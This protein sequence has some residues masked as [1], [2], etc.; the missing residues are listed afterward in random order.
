MEQQKYT[1]FNKIF[2]SG[3][4]QL[5]KNKI[6]DGTFSEFFGDWK[7]IFSFSKRYKWIIV[8][9]TFIGIFSSSFALIASY[10]GKNL[11]NIIVEKQRQHLW[12][13]VVTM[14]ASTVFSLVFSSVM[15]RLS[16][17]ISIYVNNDIQS[18]IFDK[19]IDARWSELNKYQSGD[20]LNRFNA[21]VNTISS[22]AIHW[23]PN[24]IINIYTFAVTFVV[25]FRMDIIMAVIAVTAA[26]FLLLMSRFIMRKMKEYKKRV[27]ELNSD[28]MSFEVETFFNFDMIKSFGIVGYYSR[29][30]K[31]WQKK[32][33][34]YNLDYNKFEIK[35][36]IL[37]TVL[38]TIVSL[39]AFGYCLFRLWT[40]Q[41]LYGDMTFF[42]EQRSSL[43]G[44]FNSLVG[45]F[46]AMMNSA[47]SAH[48]VRELVELQKEEHDP[49]SLKKMSG[50]ADKGLEV[51]LKEVSFSYN[52][53]SDV[54]NGGSFIA[55][56]GEIVAVLGSSGEGKTTPLR[57]I[58]GLIK[59]ENGE[60]TLRGAD[61]ER[62]PV[63]ADL[64]T[65]FSYVPQGN[66]V[67]SGTIAENMR[68][69]KEDAADEEIIAALKTAC[70]WEFVSKLPQ[71]IYSGLKDN[72]RGISMG[73]GQRISI[74]RSLLKNAPVIML[75][76]AT[77]ALDV[78]TEQAVLENIIT[79]RSDKTFIIST[80]RPSVLKQ[81]TRIYRIEDKK[82]NELSKEQIENIMKA[83]VGEK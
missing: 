10:I 62:V 39:I 47:V 30:L 76:E 5:L 73:Q 24:L 19:I 50:I 12:I 51:D 57:M 74:A 1:G 36:N 52:D 42:L 43:T 67:L 18:R 55:R 14:V 11:I 72:G 75:D 32:Y 31:E 80:H 29:K 21:D 27:L 70:A 13:L 78:E 38:G 33:K 65:L 25:L 44:K 16:A 46:P 83:Y 26:P 81:C 82:I 9:Y 71:G 17:K 2:K 20:L 60:V 48:R 37:M 54:Y 28:M 8:L 58:L 3:T 59:P 41:I 56:P 61:G 35:A 7:W 34:E 23:I 22:N 53:S 40:G 79:K 77:S 15:S 45:T 66:T 63:N 4:V 49:E 69:V 68:M 64:R 6:D